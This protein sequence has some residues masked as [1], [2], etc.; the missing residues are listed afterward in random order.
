MSEDRSSARDRLVQDRLVQDRLA[1]VRTGSPLFVYGTL[2]F[3]GVTSALLGRVPD[4]APASVAGWR[5]AAL[6][7]RPYPGLVRAEGAV[8]A[9]L[10]LLG[11]SSA[12]WRT[13]D[14]FEGDE[15]E[16]RRLPL[17]GAG[18]GHGWVYVWGEGHGTRTAVREENWDADAF[19]A[20][21][22]AGYVA[23]LTG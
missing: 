1:N 20:R 8:T 4:G 12:E 2:L 15:Y 10:L 13:L 17:G 3:P 14:D 5:A 18:T 6:D 23:R 21:R 7:G 22:L 16:L 19:A 11:L 9:G